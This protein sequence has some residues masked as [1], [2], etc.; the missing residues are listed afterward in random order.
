MKH[1]SPKVMSL[2]EKYE[3]HQILVAFDI[4]LTLIQPDHPA[5]YDLNLKKH[6]RAF[7]KVFSSLSKKEIENIFVRAL[8]SVSHTIVDPDSLEFIQFLRK[9]QITTIALTAMITGEFE[10]KLIEEH[11]FDHLTSL[12]FIFDTHFTHKIHVFDHLPPNNGTYPAF[13]N[14]ILFSNGERGE[15]HKG[16][17]IV[18]FLEKMELDP[19]C[20]VLVD[21]RPKNLMD[22]ESSLKVYNPSIEFIG[23]E[24]KGVEENFNVEISQE[25]FVNFWKNMNY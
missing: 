10:G 11:R 19:L 15:S 2:L 9:K 6:H 13:Y 21:D 12:G 25:D 20:V 3:P 4:D 8:L 1:V 16:H 18:A 7:M 22:V 24:Y 5:I 23:I 14:G 17:A